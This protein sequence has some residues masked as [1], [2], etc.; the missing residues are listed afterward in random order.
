MVVGTCLQVVLEV[1]AAEQH[2][3]RCIVPLTSGLALAGM[4]EPTPTCGS[5]NAECQHPP[6]VVVLG[7]GESGEAGCWLWNWS[8]KY[9]ADGVAQ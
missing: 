9:C 7:V 8:W 2:L 5:L 3:H 6:V 1:V 4:H